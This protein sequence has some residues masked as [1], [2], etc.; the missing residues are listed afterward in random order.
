VADIDSPS[1]SLQLLQIDS[2]GPPPSMKRRG[3]RLQAAADVLKEGLGS[4]RV[5]RYVARVK[6]A[7]KI[8]PR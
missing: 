4:A 3:S 8:A 7:V 2:V 1:A 5:K 6:I